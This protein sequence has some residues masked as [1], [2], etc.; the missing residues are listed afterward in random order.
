MIQHYSVQR[1]VLPIAFLL[2]ASSFILLPSRVIA[3]TQVCIAPVLVLTT[4]AAPPVCS[5]QTVNLNNLIDYSAS[6]LPIGTQFIF[7]DNNN[8]QVQNPAAITVS[9]T[10]WIKAI[11]GSCSDQKSVTVTI[12]QTP[13]VDLPSADTQGFFCSNENDWKLST[14]TAT[15]DLLTWEGSGVIANSSGYFFS[16]SSGLGS[17]SLIATSSNGCAVSMVVNV[18]RAPKLVLKDSS[19]CSPQIVE[20]STLIDQSAS[21]IPGGSTFQYSPSNGLAGQTGLYGI[22]VYYYIGDHILGCSDYQFAQVTVNQAPS[23]TPLPIFC[24]DDPGTYTLSATSS[25]PGLIYWSGDG[26][27]S[28]SGAIFF[29][30]PAFAGVGTHT[31]VATNIDG[32]CQASTQ[33]TVVAPPSLSACP[34]DITVSNDPG[35]C[36]AVV[37]YGAP[38]A[39][40]GCGNAT[41][42]PSGP[43]SGALF[44]IGTTVLAFTLKNAAG[45]LLSSCSFKVTVNDTEKPVVTCNGDQNLNN[46]PGQCGARYSGVATATDNCAEV[47]VTGSRSDGKPLSDLYPVG[48]TSITWTATDAAGNIANCVQKINVTDNEKPSI[49]CPSAGV[50]CFSAGNYTIPQLKAT[51]NCGLSTISYN[52][53]GA[54]TRSGLGMDASGPLNAGTSIIS[55][56]VLDVNGNSSNCQTSFFVNNQFNAVIPNTMV[57]SKGADPNTVYIGYRPLIALAVIPSG[58][59]TPYSYQWS[60]GLTLPLIIVAPN[61]PTTYTVTITDAKGCKQTASRFIN[62]KDVRCGMKAD[63]VL[64]CELDRTKDGS[65]HITECVSMEKVSEKLEKGATLGACPQGAINTRVSPRT[66]INEEKV[67]IMKVMPNPSNSQFTL[68]I[69]GKNGS[70]KLMLTIYDVLGKIMEQR[71]LFQNT[72]LRMGGLYRPGIYFAVL[73]QGHQTVTVK[74]VKSE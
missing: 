30:T 73:R 68:D 7:Y 27:N 63:K 11:S 38:S 43:A 48:N 12:N 49:I 22:G 45:T 32:G 44:P 19:V 55:W 51:D 3:Q 40:G 18:F 2:L 33:V 26:V 5:P 39:T 67:L 61:I 71:E 35:K 37:N 52:I 13:V 17:H 62:V 59:T 42:M 74:M 72:Q 21:F 28:L 65:I 56:I 8:N 15:G 24:I 53:T 47:T 4:S 36:G 41:L 31:L 29:F 20:L 70:G 66:Q 64:V 9:G 58:G 60:N 54:T 10:Y 34:T 25:T 57:L 16:S 46:D 1:H 6:T 23:I 50:L 69:S 14:T